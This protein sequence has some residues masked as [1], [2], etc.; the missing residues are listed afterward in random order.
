MGRTQDTPAAGTQPERPQ[1]VRAIQVA[2]MLILRH[3][4]NIGITNLILNNLVYLTQV[5]AL[6]AT[7]NPIFS[8]RIEAWDCGP[9]EPEVY[10]ACHKFG[11]ERVPTPKE[12][13]AVD[14]RMAAIVD[15]TVKKYGRLNAFDL[16]ELSHREG[17][18]WRTI[19]KHGKRAEITVQAIL[20]SNDGL[21]LP[22][23]TL[24]ASL[25]YVDRRW[26][27][28]FRILCDN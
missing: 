7:G 5:E 13:A 20:D 3:G 15:A 6:R 8:D 24:A 21:N 18:A 17:S 1:G 2:D 28:T 26:P 27:N 14:G 19:Y 23:R 22:K 11:F 10:A 4:N 9:V 12:A 16:M 25:D